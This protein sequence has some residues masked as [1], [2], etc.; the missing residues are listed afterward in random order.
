MSHT[1]HV[2]SCGKMRNA[3]VIIRVLP[4]TKEPGPPV[5]VSRAVVTRRGFFRSG[6]LIWLEYNPARLDIPCLP[7]AGLESYRHRVSHYGVY[8]RGKSHPWQLPSSFPQK[9]V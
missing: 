8:P 9:S 2:L 1:G 3:C 4:F 6:R 5:P 7:L